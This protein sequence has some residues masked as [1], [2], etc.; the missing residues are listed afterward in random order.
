MFLNATSFRPED[1]SVLADE[2]QIQNTDANR[3]LSSLT[4]LDPDNEQI[5]FS[6]L[7]W[8]KIAYAC[9]KQP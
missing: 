2:T 8:K 3:P 7:F 4:V 6:E 1:N 9:E 5:W